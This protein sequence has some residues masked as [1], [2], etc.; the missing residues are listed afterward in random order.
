MWPGDSSKLFPAGELELLLWH[1][2]SS[3]WPCKAM[4]V[5]S[6][7]QE[8]EERGRRAAERAD[9]GWEEKLGSRVI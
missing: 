4:A 6:S 5:S 7:T 1:K 3:W 9:L 2:C 8:S